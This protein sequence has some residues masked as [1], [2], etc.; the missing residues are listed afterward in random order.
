MI[1]VNPGV[2]IPAFCILVVRINFLVKKALLARVDRR[3]LTSFG[4]SAYCDGSCTPTRDG[5]SA[6]LAVWNSWWAEGASPCTTKR[7]RRKRVY[8]YF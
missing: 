8:Q 4:D 1:R 7:T 6:T 3:M 5:S 2:T